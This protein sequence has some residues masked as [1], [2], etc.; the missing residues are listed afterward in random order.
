LAAF[1]H[2]IDEFRQ[3]GTT[4]EQRTEE[5]TRSLSTIGTRYVLVREEGRIIA[6]AG[7]T[8]ENSQS[9]M[10]VDV[11]T[12]P[13]HRGLGWPRVWSVACVPCIKWKAVTFSACFMTSFSGR[14]LPTARVYRCRHL[15]D[16]DA[17]QITGHPVVHEKRSANMNDPRLDKLAT[18][19]MRHSTALE[20]GDFFQI[21]SAFAARPLVNAILRQ[22]A[23]LGVYPVIHWQ[24]EELTRLSYDI[25]SRKTRTPCVFWRKGPT[26]TSIAGATWQ[27][28]SRSGRP[29]TTRNSMPSRR[30]A[31]S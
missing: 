23:Q 2:S 5:I 27:P 8:A 24:D 11:A 25:Q 7:T 10:V 18:V 22:A 17:A 16:G 3:I 9:A 4:L 26:G 12:A 30:S 13:G 21:S 29:K 31:S 6:C 19:L 20:P 1:L 14:H 15:G 28:I